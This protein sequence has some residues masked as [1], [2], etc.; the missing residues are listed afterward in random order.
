MQ[1]GLLLR[2]A[3]LPMLVA[4]SGCASWVEV[5]SAY[6]TTCGLLCG[7]YHPTAEELRHGLA[8][9]ET[10]WGVSLFYYGVIKDTCGYK[11]PP[12]CLV[13]TALDRFKRCGNFYGI[14]RIMEEDV[15]ISTHSGRRSALV[16]SL[17][18]GMWEYSL[19]LYKS[20]DR[21]QKSISDTRILVNTLAVNG[22]WS[23]ALRLL[24]PQSSTLLSC[25]FIKSIVRS[26]ALAGEHEKMLRLVAASL[27]QGHRMDGK[28][29]SVLIRPLQKKR[30]LA[31][32]VGCGRGFGFS[33]VF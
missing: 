8:R 1:K 18:T 4:S 13:S 11:Q 2:N 15:D 29:F 6:R 25:V 16:Y 23:E 30:P 5:L 9:M 10:S 21:M 12:P 3:L 26:L 17:F 28:L 24:H 19:A 20:S 14:R 31:R 27:A 22:R 7:V 32:C 33:F